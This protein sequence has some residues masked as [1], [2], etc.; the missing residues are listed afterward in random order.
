MI[1]IAFTSEAIKELEYELFHY[2][3]P[4]VQH[5]ILV[6]FLKSH[7]LSHRKICEICNITE[8]TLTN[9]FKIY[10]K[11]GINSLK[12]LNYKGKVSKLN[13]HKDN[14]EKYFTENPIRSSKE[15]KKIIEEKTGLKRSLTQVR[16]FL[17]RIGLKYLKVGCVPGKAATEQKIAEQENY[18]LNELNPTLEDAKKGNSAIFFWTHP[19][20]CTEHS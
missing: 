20:S 2:P 6:L 3:H 1:K 11:G 16:D 7:N 17:K 5:R 9:Y 14:L 13:Y 4:K 10:L 19:T 8:K 12:E 15:A 18:I